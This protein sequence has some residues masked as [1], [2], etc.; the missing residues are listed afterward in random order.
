MVARIVDELRRRLGG[1]F[2][3]AELMA[4]YE[5]GTEWC[6]ELAV[7]AEPDDPSAWDAQT[8][9]DAA[10]NRYLREASDYAGGRVIEPRP[11]RGTTD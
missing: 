10:F 4:L 9:T 6:L 8:V 2:E 11:N 7:A 1:R 5:A 3:T